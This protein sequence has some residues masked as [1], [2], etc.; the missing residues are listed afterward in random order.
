MLRTYL[1]M[2]VIGISADLSSGNESRIKSFW[3]CADAWTNS[4]VNLQ[5]LEVEASDHLEVPDVHV[6]TFSDAALMWTEP[7]VKIEAFYDLVASLRTTIETRVGKTYCIVSRGYGTAHHSFPT[8]G[9]HLQTRTGGP[10][11]VNVGISGAVWINLWRAD[12]VIKRTKNWHAKYSLYCV[13]RD[14]RP[15]A[16]PILDQLTIAQAD[17]TSVD[18]M[19]LG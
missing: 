6:V 14:A 19:A 1:L 16:R 18:I 12:D 3:E 15:S 9:G 4:G 11:Y 5:P 13:G 17:G 10:A 2:D 7:E 8:L